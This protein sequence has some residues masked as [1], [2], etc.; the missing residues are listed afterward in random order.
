MADHPFQ[1]LLELVQARKLDPWDVDL[2]RL[3]RIYFRRPELKE[4]DLRLA[5]RALLSA[6]ILLRIKSD[7]ALNGYNGQEEPRELEELVDVAL[8][9]L[10]PV[11]LI[12]PALR[13]ITLHDLLGALKDALKE[14]PSPKPVSKRREKILRSLCDFRINI[15][16]HLEELHRRIARLA[17]RGEVITLEKLVHRPTKLAVARTL[18]LLLF[19]SNQ[20]KVRLE[21]KEPFGE[22]YVS[23]LKPPGA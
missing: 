3:A 21:Q 13:Q 10:G 9:E 2:E 12:R 7:W 5:G 23:L 16:K 22:I 19:L 17:E 6:S 11:A 20:R 14:I 18:L 1:I 15:Q 4:P 8:P